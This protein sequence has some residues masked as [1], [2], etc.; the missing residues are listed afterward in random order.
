VHLN[1][2]GSV[3]MHRATAHFGHFP[4]KEFPRAD[5]NQLACTTA[6][7]RI[8]GIGR[9]C[10][11]SYSSGKFHTLH[12]CRE[13][14]CGYSSHTYVRSGI[15]GGFWML[16]ERMCPDFSSSLYDHCF[17][18]HDINNTCLKTASAVSHFM[19]RL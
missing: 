14:Y 3:A 19:I 1:T 15:S 2:D 8:T 17:R 18:N 12:L 11:T 7:D 5:G 13:R 9:P 10:M 6:T 16:Q 4:S